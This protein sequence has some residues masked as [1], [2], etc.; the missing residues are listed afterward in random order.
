MITNPN[1]ESMNSGLGTRGWFAGYRAFEAGQSRNTNPH[2]QGS[3]FEY[4]WDT[5]WYHAQLSKEDD[6]F[7]A[8]MI[9]IWNLK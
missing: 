1:P 3:Q 7:L 5:G 4:D 2:S 9:E 6:E 8:T